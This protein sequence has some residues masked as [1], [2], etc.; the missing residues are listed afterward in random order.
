MK[1]ARLFQIIN[2]YCI[3]AKLWKISLVI[4]V[5]AKPV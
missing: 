4:A 1:I 2:Y 3:K 5:I